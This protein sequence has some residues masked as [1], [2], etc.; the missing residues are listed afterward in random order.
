MYARHAFVALTLAAS[1]LHARVGNVTWNGESAFKIGDT[2]RVA[3]DSTDFDPTTWWDRLDLVA[4]AR[5]G[6]GRS[7]PGIDWRT[8]WREVAASL[9]EIVATRIEID[10]PIVESTGGTTP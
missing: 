10:V 9:D 2:V 4:F 1:A 5:G 3:F 7:V 6:Y 8:M